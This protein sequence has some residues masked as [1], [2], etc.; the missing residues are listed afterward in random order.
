MVLTR[1]TTGDSSQSEPKTRQ[2]PRGKSRDG[3]EDEDP[4]IPPDSASRGR[5]V[6]KDQT[7]RDS[8]APRPAAPVRRS[9]RLSGDH[10][11]SLAQTLPTTRRTRLT[12]GD[13]SAQAQTETL[14]KQNSIPST[15]SGNKR[16]PASQAQVKPT[17]ILL[18]ESSGTPVQE[19]QTPV[20][21]SKRAS[22]GSQDTD[23]PTPTR[24]SRRLSGDIGQ[25]TVTDSPDVSKL[26]APAG[27]PRRRN[28][29]GTPELSN[30]ASDVVQIN[31]HKKP[32]CEVKELKGSLHVIEESDEQMDIDNI[33]QALICGEETLCQNPEEKPTIKSRPVEELV[34]IDGNSDLS[35]C[36]KTNEKVIPESKT[37]SSEGLVKETNARVAETLNMSTLDVTSEESITR[38]IENIA[39]DKEID[40]VGLDEDSCSLPVTTINGQN[41]AVVGDETVSTTVVTED[42][43]VRSSTAPLKPINSEEMPSKDREVSSTTDITSA[44][45]NE[46]C[47]LAKLKIH[48]K[49]RQ[50][51]NSITMS[52]ENFELAKRLI[53]LKNI[54]RG[55]PVSGR[56]WKKEKERFRSI[57]K[58]ATGKKSWAKKMKIKQDRQNVVAKSLALEAEKQRKMDELKERRRLNKIRTEENARKSEIVQ[59]IKDPKK[60]KK[61]KKKQ[62]RYIQTR[63]TTDLVQKQKN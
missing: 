17:G 10:D 39:N 3:G 35:K 60:I 52:D 46:N 2:A 53:D 26:R 23:L 25:D 63:D 1:K 34:G 50:I 5:L 48:D 55:L 21:R 16:K 27:R 51:N 8:P 42:D 43:D 38:G 54:P 6:I 58:D 4:S 59:V 33:S 47:Q 57:N 11:L 28:G 24:R 31:I 29:A 22:V 18:P 56:W 40:V 30:E 36:F 44:V 7:D 12:S 61:M 13:K 19:H 15:N 20:K 14:A 37:V 45:K 62:L 9:R 49:R 41:T 32:E